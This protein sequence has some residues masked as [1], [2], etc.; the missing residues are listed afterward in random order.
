VIS[1]FLKR[2]C[3]KEEIEVPIR[4]SLKMIVPPRRLVAPSQHPMTILIFGD[5][6]QY[7]EGC[8]C[9]MYIRVYLILRYRFSDV[10]IAAW[11]GLHWFC[12][13]GTREARLRN[14]VYSFADIDS[15][16]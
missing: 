13:Y 8:L 15:Q 9:D 7:R 12:I 1:C 11:S 6:A 14:M 10:S 3:K 16:A 2:S 4:Y 5:C